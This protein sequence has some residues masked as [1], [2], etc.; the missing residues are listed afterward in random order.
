M[1]SNMCY[2]EESQEGG[3]TLYPSLT[4]QADSS[5]QGMQVS[6]LPQR[7]KFLPSP[8]REGEPL[9]NDNKA[10]S[11]NHGIP[12]PVV[13]GTSLPWLC[14]VRCAWHQWPEVKCL[15]K[16]Y[17]NS[18]LGSRNLRKDSKAH[19]WLGAAETETVYRELFISNH[20][21]ISMKNHILALYINKNLHFNDNL[22]RWQGY[23]KTAIFTHCS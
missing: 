4:Q 1:L 7:I 10:V 2:Q 3:G 20:I 11:T 17:E 16:C 18:L 8:L 9:Q 13:R 21:E 22:S 19:Y 5:T 15:Q 12:G 14:Q 6:N 23:G